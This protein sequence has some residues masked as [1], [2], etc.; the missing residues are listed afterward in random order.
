MDKQLVI[1]A[2]VLAVAALMI[3]AGV[4]MWSVP[5][6]MVVA[7]ILVAAFGWLLLAD[8]PEPQQPKGPT[9]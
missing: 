6:G 5:A 4:A 9:K 1:L 2:I 8:A 7:G 3:A